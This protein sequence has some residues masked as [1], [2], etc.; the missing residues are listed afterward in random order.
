MATYTKLKSGSWGI[1]ST[2]ALAEGDSVTVTKR[3]GGQKVEIV[4][5]IVRCGDGVWIAAVR[6]SC[7]H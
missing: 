7:T 1:R 4:D 3:D 5:K 2:T 6:K